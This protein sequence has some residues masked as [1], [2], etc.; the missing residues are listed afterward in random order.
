[1]QKPVVFGMEHYIVGPADGV[2]GG[3]PRL[4]AC[5]S[6]IAPYDACEFYV[7]NT[8][9]RRGLEGRCIRGCVGFGANRVCAASTLRSSL[10][11]TLF[12]GSGRPMALTV[13][14]SRC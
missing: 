8:T 9:A 3:L 10:A 11:N 12:T 1:M 4:T 6:A 13:R 14:Q 7:G 5:H 2:A